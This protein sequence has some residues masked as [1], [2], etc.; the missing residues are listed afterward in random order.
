MKSTNAMAEQSRTSP[1]VFDGAVLT[2]QA[3]I[4][5]YV[6]RVAGAR[7]AGVR[8]ERGARCA[9]D[10]AGCYLAMSPRAVVATVARS[11]TRS[12]R[13]GMRKGRKD[14]RVSLPHKVKP[15]LPR[16]NSTVDN[17]IRL[18]ASK[19]LATQDLVAVSG[20]HTIGFSHYD[21][22]VSRLYDYHGT[23]LPPTPQSTR[24]SSKRCPCPA[25]A[26][27][28]IRCRRHLRRAYAFIL[29]PHVL[30]QPGGQ[31]GPVGHGPGVVLGLPEASSAGAGAGEGQGQVLRGLRCGHG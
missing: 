27:T 29:R 5:E 7:E 13:Q 20:A 28:A 24:A 1:L 26:S 17:L 10:R 14:S 31:D 2:R 16:P 15:N 25:R 11:I 4:P 30:H 22:F 18:F 3:N 23:A 21:Q 19:G 12:D 8:D 6:V 9:Y